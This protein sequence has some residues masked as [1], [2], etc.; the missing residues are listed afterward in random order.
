MERKDF[1]AVVVGAGPNGL[2]AAIHLQRQGL[3]VLVI[4]GKNRIGGGL[5]TEELTLPGFLHDTC[6]AIHPL[7]AA[8]PFFRELPL[9]EHG[10]QWIY[11]PVEAAHPFDNGEATALMRSVTETANLLGDPG[12]ERLLQPLARQWPGLLPDILAPLHFP[13][14]PLNMAAFGLHGLRSAQALAGRFATE[15]SRG[16]WAGMAAHSMLPLSY[17]ATSAIGLVLM[18]S[19]HVSGWPIPKGGSYAIARA[20][21]AYFTSIGGQIELNRYVQSMEQL[22]SARAILLDTSP[23]QL[24]QI[25]GQQVSQKEQRQL[26]K[27]RYGMGV[28][29]IDWAL[30]GPVP[31]ANPL[32][33]QAG[34]VHLGNRFEEI[35]GSE[36]FVWRGGHPEKPFVLFA[37]QSLFDSSRVP[38]GRHTGWAYCHVPN[39]STTDMTKAIEQ[40]IERFAPGFKERI[41]AKHTI[42]AVEMEE[43]NPNYVGGDI[44]GGAAM[45][46]QLFTRPALRFTPYRTSVRGVYLCSASTPPGGGVHGMCGYHAAKRVLK[47]IFNRD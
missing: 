40:Q 10:L 4:E 17:C 18:A 14:H 30:A 11:P 9:E 13:R 6:S 7:A 22:P 38:D 1:D 12:Y 19:G 23:G 33:R 16:L 34:T 24:L 46:S 36:Q 43:R 2:A 32:C 8:S 20:L 35:A 27:F 41:L 29:K 37:Q 25:A 45:L 42:N 26:R 47:E 44:N 5:A 3:S 31:F 39:G 15:G 28:F 21:G